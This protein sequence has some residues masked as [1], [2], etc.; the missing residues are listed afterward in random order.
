MIANH[1]III[2]ANVNHKVYGEGIIVDWRTN[3]E[4]YVRFEGQKLKD[5]FD[6]DDTELTL[7]NPQ[8]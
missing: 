5:I 4:I 2:G 7:I 3:K 6:Y 1:E 8:S